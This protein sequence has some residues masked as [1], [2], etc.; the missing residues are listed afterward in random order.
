MSSASSIVTYTS[1]YTDSESGR[2]FW[3]T[4]EEISEG[5]IPRVIAHDPDYVPE[6]VYP[7]YIPLEDEH[8]F[9]A[10]EQPLP[11]VDSPIA[12]SHG[13]I[14]ELDPE[15]DPEE[16]EDDETE[17]GLVDFPMDVG[18]DGD[19]DDD[20]DS[21]GDDAD[22]ED[23]DDEDEEEEEEEEE[24][25][26]APTDS[27]IVVPTD[28]PAS[29]SLPPEV[30]DER[31]LA[32]TTPS[33]SP[34][35]SLS[36]PS[37]GERL[38]R[39]T[40]P[41]AHSSPPP[42]PSP[43]LPSSGCLTQIQ[44]LRIASTQALINA[45]IAALPSPPLPPLPSSLYISSPVDRRVD[46][47]KTELP[48]RKRLCLSTLGSSTVD[49]EARR[50]GISEVRYGIRDTWVDPTETVPEVTPMTEG[51][52]NT[53]VTELAELHEHDTQDLYALLDDAQDSRSRIS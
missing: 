12:E 29:I 38:A 8:V 24:E 40:A 39:C 48:P 27:T 42:V 41:P 14:T 36:P 22:D 6:P 4:D 50:Q 35:I 17:D 51:E 25:H 10:E 52:V 3:G 11:P 45:V 49:A 26:L 37:T 30:E 1:V 20:D 18:D 23:D 34:P 5:G 53:R 21:T 19:N 28:E 9:L 46:V 16:Y 33:P 47:P 13:Y 31:L 32:M 15:E 44:T 43:L 7:E 2:V